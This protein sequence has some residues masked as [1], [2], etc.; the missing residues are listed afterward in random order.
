MVRSTG[1]PACNYG[2]LA[3]PTTNSR[4]T[5]RLI[6]VAHAK[7]HHADASA[8]AGPSGTSRLN[9]GFWRLEESASPPQEF[10]TLTTPPTT[11]GV[12][13]STPG[14]DVVAITSTH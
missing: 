14:G 6:T 2:P 12:D 9:G 5:A 10:A 4:A 1:H 7:C 3:S 11:S 13:V 8:L